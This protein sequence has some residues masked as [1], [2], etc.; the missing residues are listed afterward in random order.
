MLTK[1]ILTIGSTEHEIPDECL[2]N[3]DEIAFSLKR[4]DYSGV[5]RSYSTE[6]VFVGDIYDLLLA[7]YLDKG[8]LAEASVAVY[9]ITDTHEWERQFSAPLDFSTIEMEN[10]SMRINALDNALA[11][12]LKSK[13][14]QK[15]EYAVSDFE[16]ADVLLH[17]ITLKNN[18][19]F[20]FDF[21]SVAQPL[22]QVNLTYRQAQSAVIS[23]EY[24][25][26]CDQVNTIHT[27]DKSVNRF[28]ATCNKYGASLTCVVKG[29]V[30]CYLAPTHFGLGVADTTPVQRMELVVLTVDS[31]DQNVE[32]VE[33][34]MFTDNILLKTVNGVQYNTL[35]NGTFARR[36]N[37]FADME[38]YIEA[39]H[40][41]L[42][43]GMFGIV[44][45]GEY[46][47]QQYWSNNVYEYQDGH[48]LAKGFENIRKG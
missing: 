4:T 22:D 17:R 1:Y 43:D 46:G 2:K 28:F 10:G 18:A 8:L 33:N 12:L 37:T 16:T 19:F 26:M 20:V 40:I 23:E 39:N 41:T 42:Y 29:V 25:S 48:W 35:I 15:Y 5:M 27:G 9:T 34:V 45:T 13:K 44:G 32:H 11:S 38:A 31:E 14:S 7:E 6:F 36:F 30:R 3:W 21:S 24:L 47:Y